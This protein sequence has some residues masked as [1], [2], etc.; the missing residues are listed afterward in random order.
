MDQNFQPAPASISRDLWSGVKRAIPIV[1]A[2]TPF[3]L[4]FGAI[5]HDSG[6]SIGEAVFMSATVY[7]GASQ[8]VGLDL[9]GQNIAPWMIVFSIFAVNFRHVLYSASVGRRIR[10]FSF[11]QKAAAFY[12]MID[13]QYAEVEMRGEAGHK[14]SFAWYMGLGLTMYVFWMLQTL[15]GALFGNLIT[16]P[17]AFGFD[18]LLPIY[19]LGMVMSFRHREN[20]VPVVI[21]STISAVAAYKFVGSPWHVTL[22]ASGGVILAA[23]LAKPKNDVADTRNGEA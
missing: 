8:L 4:L 18:F 17:Y 15:V 11:M 10:H 14:I 6:L 2:S 23:I 19:F 5:A 12:V 1:V 16:D 7:A 9:F 3:G 22:G 13:P 21:A 20:W